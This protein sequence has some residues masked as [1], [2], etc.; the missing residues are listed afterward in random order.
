MENLTDGASKRGKKGLP[1]C[2]WGGRLYYAER[3]YEYRLINYL[4]QGSAAD[5]TKQVLGDWYY[6]FRLPTDVFLATV[7]D[8]IN[9][10]VPEDD[11]AGGMERLR[12]AMDQPYFD[13][14]MRSEGFIGANWHDIRKWCDK[15]KSFAA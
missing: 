6:D 1:I 14:P 15:S 10:S 5:Q 3:G 11:V 2:T 13:T 12:E 9:L 7:H 4:I 8:E